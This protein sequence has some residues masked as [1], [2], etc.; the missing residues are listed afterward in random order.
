[1]M[2][3]IIYLISVLIAFP[4]SAVTLSTPSGKPVERAGIILIKDYNGTPCVLVGRN[5][6][7]NSVNLVNFP[8]GSCERKDRFPSITAAR[9]TYEETGASLKYDSAQI[10]RMPYVYADKHQL[11]VKNT[12]ASVTLLTQSV[13]SALRSSLPGAYKEVSQ[14]YAVPIQNL[15][16]AAKAVNG[17]RV[18]G[19]INQAV[20]VKRGLN[21]LKSRNGHNLVFD[22]HYLATIAND[23]YNAKNVF[24][25]LTGRRFS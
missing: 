2:K 4:L 1:M 10:S 8:A 7:V 16:N 14:Y 18:N 19:R 23:Y 22:S 12:R 9:E 11:F 5:A 17:S 20:I 13:Q 15:L 24:E 3:K 21:R 25:R 6:K